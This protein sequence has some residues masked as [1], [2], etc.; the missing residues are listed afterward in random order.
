MKIAE[1]GWTDFWGLVLTAPSLDIRVPVFPSSGTQDFHQQLP[2]FKALGPRLRVA[3]STSLLRSP[4]DLDQVMLW[5]VVWSM[6]SQPTFW[7]EASAQIL[8]FRI[9]VLGPAPQCPRLIPHLQQQQHSM[10]ALVQSQLL[11]AWKTSGGWF[12]SLIP[13]NYMGDQETWLQGLN[14]L[15]SGHCMEDLSV[16]FSQCKI[17]LQMKIKTNKKLGF[18]IITAFWECLDSS[19]I[20]SRCLILYIGFCFV[21]AYTF[22]P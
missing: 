12:K 2:S 11:M 6:P 1:R 4:L 10:W 19:L 21:F 3:Q 16:L 22:T 9:R 20:P 17:C 13:W 15:S 18:F 7:D 5:G 8:C 14:W